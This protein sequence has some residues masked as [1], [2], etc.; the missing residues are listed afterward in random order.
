MLVVMSQ[1]EEDMISDLEPIGEGHNDGTD[2]QPGWPQYVLRQKGSAAP[3]V[4]VT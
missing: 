1:H 3:E 4:A 2:L